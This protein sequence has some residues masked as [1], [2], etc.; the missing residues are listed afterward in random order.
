[1]VH[2]GNI[3]PIEDIKLFINNIGK[4]DIIT[5]YISNDNRIF[6]RKYLSKIYT[7]IIRVIS[8]VSLKYYQGA[9]ILLRNDVL[10]YHSYNPGNSYFP[11]LLIILLNKGRTVK[12]IEINPIHNN[13]N[14]HL[15]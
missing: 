7:L 14:L 1:M 4:A 6:L 13:T 11:E 10:R 15:L 3:L 9:S 12:E 2:S 8:G 5:S